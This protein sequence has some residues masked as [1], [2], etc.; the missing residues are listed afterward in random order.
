[1]E[2]DPK[3]IAA[4]GYPWITIDTGYSTELIQLYSKEQVKYAKKQFNKLIREIESITNNFNG[5]KK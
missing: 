2:E 1:M 4:K 5:V 3:K